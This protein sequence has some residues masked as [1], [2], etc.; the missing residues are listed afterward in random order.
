MAK[1]R[2][3]GFGTVFNIENEKVGIG[4][5]GK[6]FTEVRVLKNL[7]LSDANVVTQAQLENY[8]GFLSNEAR[9]SG[10]DVD[11]NKLVGYVRGEAY[12]GESHA[13]VR[14]DGSQINMVGS[15]HTSFSHNV[16]DDSSNIQSGAMGDIIID[17]EFTVSSGTTYCSSVDQLTSVANFTVPTG[18][19][20]DRIHC[21]TAGSMR[22][23]EELATLEFY[24]GEEWRTVNSF[25]DTGNR[26]RGITCG[27]YPGETNQIDFINLATRGNSI[28]FGDLVDSQGLFDATSSS[29]RM[30]TSGG[31]NSSF[32]GGA[33]VDIQYVTM[34]TTGD[35]IDFGDQTQVTYG[36]GA[37]SS[38]TRAL[39]MGGNRMP[40]SSPF[41][42]GNDGNNTICTIEIATIGNAIDFG[43]LSA[44]RGYPGA[45]G[46]PVRMVIFGG[47]NNSVGSPLGLKTSDTVIY[48]SHGNA[49]D[50]GEASHGGSNKAGANSTRGI[51]GGTSGGSNTYTNIM[52]TISIQ[53]LGNS[54]DFGDRTVY[55]SGSAMA[56]QTR[57][58]MSGGRSTAA[59]PYATTNVMDFVEFASSGNAQD[60]GDLSFDQAGA[61]GAS[62]SHGGLGGF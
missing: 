46:D 16:I 44:R 24:T 48:A 57:L 11:L 37:S 35:A 28:S 38:S 14:S 15:A 3:A 22:F 18:T 61:A 52:Y 62:D 2:R 9:L 23:N 1:I 56:S 50:F 42:D 41:D 19:T 47:Y 40:N 55:S 32:G 7:E 54:I 5:T 39:I 53:S 25:K 31:Y 30:V 36:T 43:D 21:H 13:H 26:G 29:T 60:F 10:N 51:W 12:Y 34:A 27:S 8:Q 4:T 49:V 58:V 6:F 45:C 20:E 17:G 59:S 33:V